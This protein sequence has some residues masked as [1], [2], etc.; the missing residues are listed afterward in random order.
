MPDTSAA[1]LDPR[2]PQHRGLY[3]GGAWHRSSSARETPIVSP[4]TG[5]S[6]GTAVE[7]TAEDIDR[8]V[9]AARQAFVL[10]RETPAQERAA[11]LRKAIAILRAHADEL[12]WLEAVDT[13]NPM[14]AMRFD[15]EIS[16]GYM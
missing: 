11:A 15:V 16:A 6:L 13:G 2:L 14:Q 1:P 5:A 10:W 4:A 12:A 8:A 9:V 7:A 3:Y